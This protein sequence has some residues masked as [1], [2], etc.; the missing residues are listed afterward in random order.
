MRSFREEVIADHTRRIREADEKHAALALSYDQEK[1][2]ST[3]LYE[4]MQK[5]ADENSVC[6]ILSSECC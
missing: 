5:L 3:H 4:Q 1:K 2:R 6:A